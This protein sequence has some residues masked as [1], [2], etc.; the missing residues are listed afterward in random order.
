MIPLPSSIRVDTSDP[1]FPILEITHPTCCAR[2]ALHG[3]HVLSWIPRD[4]DEVFYLSPETHMKAGKAIRGGIPLCW[5][6]F[7]AHPTDTSLPSHGFARIHFWNL[8]SAVDTPEK[9]ILGLSL[10]IDD[11]SAKV[12][13]S[14]GDSLHISLET[15]NHGDKS[16]HVGGA[17]HSYFSV[18]DVSQV[19]VTGLA[20]APYTDC[21]NTITADLPLDPLHFDREIDANFH[22]TCPTQLVDHDKKRIIQVEKSAAPTTV[23]WNPWIAKSQRLSDLP[24]DGYKQFVCIEPAI[25]NHERHELLPGASFSFSTTIHLRAR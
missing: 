24:D 1:A 10:T 17:M 7:S 18:G 9:I 12:E 6:W 20:G 25:L 14:F 2:L 22:T 3:A 19:H 15:R 16:R 13:I 11:L 4:Q 21:V 23:I 8:D 5:P